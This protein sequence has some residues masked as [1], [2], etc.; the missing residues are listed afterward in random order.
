MRE[1]LNEE[2]LRNKVRPVT[3]VDRKT[4][5]TFSYSKLEVKKT[6]DL[7]YDLRYNQKKFASD[8]TLA[9]ELGS[10]CHYCLEQK[11]KMLRDGKSVDYSK[12]HQILVE[13]GEFSDGNPSAKKVLLGTKSLSRKYFEEWYAKDDASGMT[14][15]E[16]ME[17][18]ERVLAKEMTEDTQGWIPKYF[19]M[20]FDFVWNNR[21]ILHGFIDRI[22]QRNDEYRTIDY[23]TSK[24]VYDQTKLATSMQFG[25][26]A[27][28]ILNE[29]GKLPVESMY[30][31]VLLD[32]KQYA[33]TKGWEKRIATALDKVL[34]S[35]TECEGKKLWKPS[36]TPLCHWCSYCQHNPMAKEYRM[37]CQ[38][39]SLWTP[40]NKVWEVNMTFDES[41]PAETAK[42]K[43]IF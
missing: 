3:D 27:L 24:K 9:L 5:P 2:L 37:E 30:R 29:F 14:Y 22:D 40:T 26:Y 1:R 12:L 43:I 23:K 39:Y 38:Y 16:K 36:P 6:C 13:G 31:F 21:A 10:L 20:P 32:E 25:I 34:D 35:I 17:V 41:K 18:F 11:G 33:L 8:T 4:L 7:Q 42:R 15:V 28:A 19:E